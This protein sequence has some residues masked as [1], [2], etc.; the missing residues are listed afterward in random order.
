L[1]WRFL[2]RVGLAA[3]RDAQ[4][5]A[6]TLPN[7]QLELIEDARTYVQIDQPEK[8]AELLTHWA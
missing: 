7:A 4:R 6:D 5:L 2:R 8:L 3:V 1:R